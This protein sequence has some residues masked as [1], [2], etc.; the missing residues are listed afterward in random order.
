[1]VP[2][3]KD[4]ENEEQDG[5]HN[6]CRCPLFPDLLGRRAALR[7]QPSGKATGR[8]ALLGNGRESL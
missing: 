2:D 5:C 6:M 3:M 1:M 4:A 8:R 7:R